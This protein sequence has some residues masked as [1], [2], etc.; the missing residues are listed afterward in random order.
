MV[1]IIILKGDYDIE[2]EKFLKSLGL[3]IFRIPSGD[4]L[5]KIDYVL[6]GLEH[7]LINN[8]EN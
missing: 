3:K 4:I 5:K 2:R 1:Y 7:Y 6:K 8:Y